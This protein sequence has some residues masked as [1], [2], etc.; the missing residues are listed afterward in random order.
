MAAILVSFC[1]LANKPLVPRSRE[2][3]LLNF[4]LKNEATRGNLKETNRT[5]LWRP[6]WN[7]VHVLLPPGLGCFITGYPI[8]SPLVVR[9]LF[10][11]PAINSFL[12]LGEEAGIQHNYLGCS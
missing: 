2:N 4:K 7:K 10:L 3:I 9:F 5:P 12:P 6:F 1:L 8:L 11:I